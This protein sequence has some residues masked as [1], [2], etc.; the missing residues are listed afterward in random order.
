MKLIIVESPTKSKTIQ[1]FL[2][3]GYKT[4]SSYGHI[5]DLPKSKIGVD[6][7]NGFEPKYVAVPG[8]AKNV[9]IIKDLAKKADTVLLATDPD[10]EGESISWHL[11]EMLGLPEEKYRR[12]VFHEITEE[13]VKN[14]LSNPRDI[15]MNLV[16]AQQARRILDRVVG[17]KLSPFLWKKVA[18]GL[19]A[20]RVQ[21]VALRFVADREKEIRNF[22]KKE[23]WSIEAELKSRNGP[24]EFSAQLAK[25]EGKKIDKFFITDENQANNLVKNIENRGFSVSDISRKD[26][27]KTPLPPFITSTMQQEA[28]KRLRFSSKM[29]M[30]VAQ[31]LYEKGLTTYHRTDSYNLSDYSVSLAKKF[32]TANYGDEYWEGR[33]YKK[34]S[35]G[36]QE[37]HEAIRPSYPERSPEKI[38]GDLDK[39]QFSLYNLIWR[40][41][42]ASLMSSAVMDQTSVDIETDPEGFTFRCSGQTVRFDGFLKV[43]PMK[44]EE[45]ILPTLESGE[46]LDL[47]NLISNQH[48]TQPPARYSEATLIKALEEKGIGRP[49]TYAPILST[50]QERSYVEKNEEKRFVP[51]DIGMVV[52]DLLSDHFP[53]IVDA[54][55]T[56]QMEKKLDGIAEGKIKWNSVLESFYS[57][58]EKLLKKKEIEI[59]KKD[60]TEKETDEVCEKCGSKMVLKVGRF[61]S[62]LACSNYPDCKNTK[63]TEEKES[64]DPCEECGS[65]MVLKRSKFG[66]FW[67][68]SNYP[69]CKNIRKDEESI[70]I[71]CPK[72]NKGDV[73]KK[74]SKRG[75]FFYG[76]NSYPECDFISNKKP[77][78]VS[79]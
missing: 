52:S 55:F 28:Y 70:G 45:K 29:T 78:S 9:K 64:D 31:Q 5:R 35:K 13:A 19:S 33:I 2:D 46:N 21:S 18:R 37:A 54:E 57:P 44:L 58:F 8:A 65:K 40:R 32:V 6:I 41:F 27:R 11:S 71:K 34:K 10:R 15:D 59:N 4:I 39:N 36:A 75:R 16:N 38:R 22:N 53:E 63:S 50:I 68:C 73:V 1:K 30:R 47:I 23:Y 48:F 67:G 62:F 20:G 25:I 56:A 79:K 3:K 66:S 74:R 49:S 61:G 42:I 43:Y 51:T 76:C 7:E 77:D 26:T 69:D 60:I 72:C 17:Y 14:S 24:P 12:I